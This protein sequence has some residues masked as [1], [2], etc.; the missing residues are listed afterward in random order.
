MHRS[1]NSFPRLG[2]TFA[3]EIH[4]GAVFE[5]QHVRKFAA[6]RAEAILLRLVEMVGLYIL[7]LVGS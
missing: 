6:I 4:G 1:K 3:M 7:R 5:I 2:R